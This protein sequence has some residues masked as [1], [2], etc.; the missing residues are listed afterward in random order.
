MLH[1][2]QY[3]EFAE[4]INKTMS[5]Q[6]LSYDMLSFYLITLIVPPLSAYYMVRP[7]QR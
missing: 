1:K 5:W 2:L 6:Y 7:H 4:L 3:R